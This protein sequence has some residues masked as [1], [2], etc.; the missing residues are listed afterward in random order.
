MSYEKVKRITIKDGQIRVCS[1]C[2]NVRPLTFSTWTFCGDK[3]LE[4][5]LRKLAEYILDGD[6]QFYNSKQNER[7]LKATKFTTATWNKYQEYLEA[8]E[9]VYDDVCKHFTPTNAIKAKRLRN[10]L[11]E[12]IANNIKLEF[13]L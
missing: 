7:W 13:N 5:R 6:L 10:E 8:S 9:Y 11:I 12:T 3:P 4:F 1:A 2:N